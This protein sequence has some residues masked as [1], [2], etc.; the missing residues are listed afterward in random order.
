[1]AQTTCVP[2]GPVS[3]GP[4]KRAYRPNRISKYTNTLPRPPAIVLT[5]S[6]AGV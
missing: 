4:L 6:Y 5:Y 2:P 3:C 1:M